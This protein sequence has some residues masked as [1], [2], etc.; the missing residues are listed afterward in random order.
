MIRTKIPGLLLAFSA[1]MML[2]SCSSSVQITG[3]WKSDR[4]DTETG[5]GNI[6]VVTMLNNLEG[7]QAVEN[8]IREVM[9]KQNVTTS[10]SSKSFPS[11]N[12]ENFDSKKDDIF[13][14]IST[15]KNDAILTISLLDKKEEVYY[16]PGG[17]AYDP[18]AFA[19][20]GNFWGYY[21]YYY[22]RTYEPGY[23]DVDNVYFIEANLYDADSQELIYSAQA[24]TFNPQDDIYGFASDFAQT[25]VRE[26]DS[27]NLLETY[28]SEPL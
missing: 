15:S 10:L 1:F 14:K 9:Q 2:S 17:Q 18:G 11:M 28:D 20:Y 6:M 8:E 26:L 3:D 4:A 22:P 13:E 23:Y 27:E 7:A 25:L 12:V 21:S 24:E 16:V 19:W 5:Y